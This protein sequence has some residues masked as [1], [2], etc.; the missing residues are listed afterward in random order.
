[1]TLQIRWYAGAAQAAGT[2]S[3]TATLSGPGSIREVLA[4]HRPGAAAVLERCSF[5]VDGRRLEGEEPFPTEAG[6]LDV[7]PPFAG[8]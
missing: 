6:T 5:L 4:A 8:G 2:E 1:M 7:L 3:E